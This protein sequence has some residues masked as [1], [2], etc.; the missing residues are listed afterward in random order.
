M[1]TVKKLFKA[2]R[3]EQLEAVKKIRQLPEDKQTKMVKSFTKTLF[4]VSVKLC[5]N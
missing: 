3:V 1:Y 5:V 4:E 2:R